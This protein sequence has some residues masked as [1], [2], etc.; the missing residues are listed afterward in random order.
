MCSEIVQSS[1]LAWYEF[2][3]ALL[4]KA[5][6]EYFIRDA[7]RQH[8]V[9]L[10]LPRCGTRRRT[11]ELIRFG[12]P[13]EL[14]TGGCRDEVCLAASLAHDTHMDR[15]RTLDAGRRRTGACAVCAGVEC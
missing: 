14:N 1:F 4:G 6:S 11:L 2:V 15:H 7:V 13:A 10:E 3:L 8:Q 12:Q 9:L 5:R